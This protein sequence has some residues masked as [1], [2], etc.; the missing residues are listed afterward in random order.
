MQIWQTEKERL[1]AFYPRRV[2]VS[3]YSSLKDLLFNNFSYYRTKIINLMGEHLKI[4]EYPKGRAKAAPLTKRNKTQFTNTSL[5]TNSIQLRIGSLNN[6]KIC[7]NKRFFSQ[8]LLPTNIS[9]FTESPINSNLSLNP[10]YLTGFT[11]GDGSFS[12][13]VSK[14]IRGKLLCKVQPVF[15][16]GLHKKDLPLLLMIHKYF[17]GGVG[18]I[19][20]RKADG[21]VYYIISSVKDII[22]YVIPHF[23]S[24]PL[25]SQKKADYLLFRE[26]VILRSKKEHLSNSGLT[27]IISLKASL[28][29]GLKGWV[30]DLFP[31]IEPAIRPEVKVL[32]VEDLNPY[33]IR[34]RQD[35]FVHDR[36]KQFY[37]KKYS[38]KSNLY[39]NTNKLDNKDVVVWG[40]NLCSTAGTGRLTNIV[41]NMIALP[42]YQ[43]SVIV[44]ILL[45]DGYLFSSGKSVNYGLYFNQG[46]PN[47]KYVW[48][49]YSRLCHYC[50]V[51]PTLKK[52]N[53]HGQ[54]SEALYFRTR[55]LPC[56]SEL[57]SIFYI[58]KKKV[59]PEDIYNL[60]TPV[61]LAHLVMGDGSVQR[62][63]L[64]I[65]TD[66]YELIDIV[67]LMNV[68]IIKYNIDC[69][70]RYHTPS[71]P[72]IYI[73]ERSM[74]IVR[75]L[76]KP[77]IA[78]CM[79]YKIKL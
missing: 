51:Y 66:S 21:T 69:K 8:A 16:F 63:G 61:A 26:I 56:L 13:L 40:T 28:N 14:D 12:I 15:T 7:I 76:V 52:N 62:H 55:G 45:S 4:I 32:R 71:Q 19:Y 23:D 43:K 18:K 38:T 34:K 42:Y 74:P 73:S 10:W 54:I 35:L 11:D 79:L 33:W 70:L 24:Y 22:K 5:I 50:N 36:I 41:K 48:F 30:V 49:V 68:L 67:R 27:K 59:I 57:R 47:S 1:T 37:S 3:E 20:T 9:K 75:N 31:N 78:E 44:G 64:I 2:W 46:I 6:F 29:L 58:N 17:F 25:V 60:L 53:S 65:C 39:S 77:Y 72:R